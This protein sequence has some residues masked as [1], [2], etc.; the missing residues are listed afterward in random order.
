MNLTIEQLKELGFKSGDPEGRSWSK[1]AGNRDA[2]FYYY[3][4]NDGNGALMPSD[5]LF[6]LNS[7]DGGDISTVY[8]P[9]LS[10]E[11]FRELDKALNS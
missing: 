10:L 2:Y 6:E 4:G 5:S 1:P 9:I 3:F 7:T 8:S 11:K